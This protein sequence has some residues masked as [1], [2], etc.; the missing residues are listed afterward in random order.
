MIVMSEHPTAMEVAADIREW[1][2]VV[3]QTI[4]AT[5]TLSISLFMGHLVSDHG[6]TREQVEE[7]LKQ[8]TEG[9]TAKGQPPGTV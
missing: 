8:V 6:Y 5:T 9:I 1:A 4:N 7:M 3:R 2:D